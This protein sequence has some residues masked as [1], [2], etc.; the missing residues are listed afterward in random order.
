VA[1]DEH[2]DFYLADLKSHGVDANHRSHRPKGDTGKCVVMI[3]PDAD[4]SMNTYLGVT[5]DLGVDC[6]DISAISDSR[7]VYIEGYLVSAPLAL[8]A[9]VEAK[10]LAKKSAVKIA[11]SLSDPGMVKFFREGID[12]LLEGG[13]DLLFCNEDEA[14]EYTGSDNLTAAIEVLKSTASQFAITLGAKGALLWDGDKLIEVAAHK[15]EAVD[16]NGAGDMFAG[17]FIY[18]LCRG[19]DMHASGDLAS[20][21]SAQVVKR[22]GPRLVESETATV[23]EFA[24]KL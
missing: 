10:R 13:V 23:R 20:F 3:T 16:T 9:A 15:V 12:Q 17:A 21:A 18:G 8:E 2:G 1:D 24:Q 11:F 4:R 22:F 14:L 6:L 5:G 7:F 19:L